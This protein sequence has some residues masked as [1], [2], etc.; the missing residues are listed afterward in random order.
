MKIKFIKK[1]EAPLQAAPAAGAERFNKS[2][3]SGTALPPTMGRVK[4]QNDNGTI[5]V[6]VESGQELRQVALLAKFGTNRDDD[7]QG[8]KIEGSYDSPKVGSSVMILFLNGRSDSPVSVG[9]VLFHYADP[10]VKAKVFN[11]PP[12]VKKTI[13]NNYEIKYDKKTGKLDISDVSGGTGSNN[14]R[15]IVDRE[16]S[17]IDFKDWNENTVKF[18]GNLLELNGNAKSLVTYDELKAAL[19][20]MVV[21][22]N[23]HT[24]ASFGAVGIPAT[25]INILPSR[26]GKIK[27]G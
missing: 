24:H 18:N 11:H 13:D 4:S 7:G 2:Y 20:S 5:N 23:A 14:F 27:T 16:G 22:I 9:S 19:D 26:S 21:L 8:D 3:L 15:L 1:R 6:V 10:A 17:T 12:N 25:T